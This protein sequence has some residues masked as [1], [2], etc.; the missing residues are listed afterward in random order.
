M[1]E[2]LKIAGVS[3]VLS[4]GLVTA[5]EVPPQ[6]AVEAAAGKIYTDRVPEGEPARFS[7][8]A[9]AAAPEN[10]ETQTP[11]DGKGDPLGKAPQGGCASQAWPHIAPECLAGSESGP[12]RGSIRTIT[13]EQRQGANVSVLV[14]VPASELVR[15]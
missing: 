14:R 1:F 15:H 13:V 5:S 7:R 3:A 11:R 9:Y 10:R 4:A 2:L 6:P 12:A 8:A